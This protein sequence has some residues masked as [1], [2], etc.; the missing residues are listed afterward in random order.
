VTVGESPVVV[1]PRLRGI[2][3]LYAFFVAIV[4]AIALVATAPSG[5]ATIGAAVY[6]VTLVGMFG[7]SALYHRGNW[8]PPMARRMLQLDHTAIFLLI[9]G[10]YTPIALL[11]ISGTEKD[12]L[13]PLVWVIAI[14]GIV[15]EWLPMPAPRGYV[16][17]VYLTLGW[18]G[19]FGMISLWEHAGPEGVLLIAAG[20]ICYTVGAIVHA[21]KRPDPW[22]E[23]FGYHEIFHVFVIAAAA[24][25]YIAIAA[26]VLPLGA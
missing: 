20:G 6:A 17:A 11:A 2:S 24:L 3:H 19:A 15:Y 14:G 25:Q 22:P 26:F 10:T 5:T 13:L 23:T 16:T 9:A 4:A 21:T 8:S 7:A 18:I 12:V 1:K